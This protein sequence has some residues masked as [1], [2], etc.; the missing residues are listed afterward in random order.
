MTS[1]AVLYANG[2]LFCTNVY[3]PTNHADKPAFLN[4]LHDCAPANDCPWIGLGGFNLTQ[5]PH[6]R[7]T[8]TF[9][10]IRQLSSMVLSTQS[11]LIENPFMGVR[12]PDSTREPIQP[13]LVST[14]FLL[15]M[16]VI[17][18]FQYIPFLFN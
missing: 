17:S 5:S 1:E 3:T 15:I 18:Y 8:Q 14:E 2:C 10:R 9:M 6:A 13:S 4:E 11:V 16:L 12:I 7:I